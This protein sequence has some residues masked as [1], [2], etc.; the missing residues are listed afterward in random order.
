M[1]GIHHEFTNREL[2]KGL[3]S[4]EQLRGLEELLDFEIDRFSR[5]ELFKGKRRLDFGSVP[6]KVEFASLFDEVRSEVDV[7]MGV[8]GIQAPN[9]NYYNKVPGQVFHN[10][11]AASLFLTG[12][13]DYAL[14]LVLLNSDSLDSFLS[15]Q[16]V[17]VMMMATGFF[18]FYKY[19]SRGFYWQPPADYTYS[20]RF[21]VVNAPKDRRANLLPL[22]GHEY[23]HHVQKK[24]GLVSYEGNE[25]M[26]AF[27]EG[28]AIGVQRHLSEWYAEKHGNE[29]YLYIVVKEST[30]NLSRAYNWLCQ[31]L[32]REPKKSLSL[33]DEL[34]GR[35]TEYHAFGDSFF[36]LLE[37]RRGKGV[38]AEMFASLTAP[39]QG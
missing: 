34:P 32:G 38:Y 13:Y 8:S 14:K 1:H 28:T 24:L 5:L 3:Q 30:Y 37:K 20:P 9:V 2:L 16:F 29:S 7:F 39:D 35:R 25:G 4:E 21:E 12:L 33:T 19:H 11:V 31:A 6:G 10:A 22:A 23:T 17:N 15:R 36:Y 18:Y 27:M 26:G